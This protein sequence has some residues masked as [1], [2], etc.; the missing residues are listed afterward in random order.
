MA[1]AVQF[2]TDES[3]IHWLPTPSSVLGGMARHHWFQSQLG[4]AHIASKKAWED[5]ASRLPVR[6]LSEDD[7]GEFIVHLGPLPALEKK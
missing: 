7:H 2:I 4:E 6:T 3:G 1:R 5:L